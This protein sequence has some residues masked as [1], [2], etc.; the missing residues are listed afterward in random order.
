MVVIPRDLYIKRFIVHGVGERA[1]HEHA[2]KSD[3]H[4]EQAALVSI[5]TDEIRYVHAL[6]LAY[7]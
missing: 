1:K 3:G 2:Y 4:V 5:E 7:V 6:P